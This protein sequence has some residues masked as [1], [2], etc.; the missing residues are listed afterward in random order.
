MTNKSTNV[1]LVILLLALSGV[2]TYA[3]GAVKGRIESSR[4][5]ALEIEAK[6]NLEVARYYVTRRKAY[7][8]A[9]DRLEEIIDS[10]PGFSRMDEVLFLMGEAHSKLN[11]PEKAE[12]YYNK[13]LK[14]YPESEFVKKAKE[15]L[16]KL[17]SDKEGKS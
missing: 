15:Q 10:H 11:K 6:H 7:A 13:L 12:D 2:S 17:K 16:E 14:D 5:A 1:L 4:D 9:I 8:G 3:Q